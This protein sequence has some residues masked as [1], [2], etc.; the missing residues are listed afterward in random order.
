MSKK[1]MSWDEKYVYATEIAL[2]EQNCLPPSVL[3][4][5][6]LSLRSSFLA[7]FPLQAH[8]VVIAAFFVLE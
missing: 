1:T 2:V 8:C 6:I 4:L 7:T 3:E 5:T